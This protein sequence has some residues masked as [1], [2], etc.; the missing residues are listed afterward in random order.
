MPCQSIDPGCTACT[1]DQY[2]VPSVCLECGNNLELNTT[3]NQCLFEHCFEWEVNID[4]LNQVSTASCQKC[5]DFYG[6]W[7]I[8]ETGNLCV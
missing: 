8:E 2:G 1:V 5:V 4:Y 6:V 3:L 7:E